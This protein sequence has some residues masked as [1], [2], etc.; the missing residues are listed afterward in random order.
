METKT[1]HACLI[2]MAWGWVKWS[3]KGTKANVVKHY[4]HIRLYWGRL[5]KVQR[6]ISAPGGSKIYQSKGR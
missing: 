5:C 6:I 2:L 3:R 1:T 4:M